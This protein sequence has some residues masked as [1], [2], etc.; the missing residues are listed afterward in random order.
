MGPHFLR[1]ASDPILRTG[2]HFLRCARDDS[3]GGS[4]MDNS[5]RSPLW[6]ARNDRKRVVQRSHPLF[7]GDRINDH[8]LILSEK[9]QASQKEER[10]S[11]V[12]A[13]CSRKEYVHKK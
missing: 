9:Q 5:V 1:C 3:N 2:P 6:V 7:N 10:V 11:M 12:L 13:V 8:H 4:S